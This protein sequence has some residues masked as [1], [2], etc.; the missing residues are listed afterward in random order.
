MENNERLALRLNNAKSGSFH[1][2]TGASEFEFA[3]RTGMENEAP[4][5]EEKEIEVVDASIQEENLDSI[6]EP[7]HEG[8]FF[9]KIYINFAIYW[10]IYSS[11]SFHM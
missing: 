6:P 7:I 1:C 10:N 5:T 9:H 4:N 8:I 3:L 11:N 2:I